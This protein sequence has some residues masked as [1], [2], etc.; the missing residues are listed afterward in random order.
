MQIILAIDIKDG[1]VVKA[2]AGFRLNYKPLHI[3]NE[4][5]SDPFKLIKYSKQRINL[6]KVYIADLNSIGKNGSNEQLID[7]LMIQFPNLIFL[8]DAGFSYPISINNYH[9]EKRIKKLYNYE[10]ILGTETLRNFNLQCYTNLKNIQFSLDFNG[11]Q[12]KWLE[13]F[14]K[15]KTELNIILMF[16]NKTGGRG[17]DFNLIKRLNKRLL[18]HKVSLAGGLSNFSEIDKLSKIGIESVLSSTLIHKRISRD[19]NY[20]P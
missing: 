11:K 4:D 3:N 10:L 1:L 18:Q 19:R 15:E 14:Y 16:M 6:Q 2:F 20:S 13:K 7:K 17:I 8:I 12:G 9:K 5:F